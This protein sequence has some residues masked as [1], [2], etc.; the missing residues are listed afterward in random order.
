MD[1][2][3]GLGALAG[4]PLEG[5]RKP[6]NFLLAPQG[7][8]GLRPDQEAPVFACTIAALEA[9]VDAV[10]AAEPRL[11][12]LDRGADPLARVYV[13]RTPALGF[14]DL[15]SLRLIPLGP[16]QA[17]LALY[18]R[19]VYGLYDFGVNRRRVRRWLAEIQSK[20]NAN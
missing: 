2:D 9:A 16:G 19:A 20:L 5:R 4:V 12:R 15:V 13:Q 11:E 7:F 17:T 18:S 10:A 8:S 1:K 3:S 14:P 6:N